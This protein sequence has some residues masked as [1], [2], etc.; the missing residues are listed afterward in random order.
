MRRDFIR[1]VNANTVSVQPDTLI[2]IDSEGLP[3]LVLDGPPQ[4][5]TT[6][7]ALARD[8]MEVIKACL[9][10]PRRRA[11]LD[12]GMATLEALVDTIRGAT[13]T[14]MPTSQPNN[15][16][17]VGPAGRAVLTS[18]AEICAFSPL[19]AQQ[20]NWSQTEA[21]LNELTSLDWVCERLEVRQENLFIRQA[22]C[23]QEVYGQLD[24]LRKLLGPTV[25]VHRGLG[26]TLKPFIKLFYGPAAK[27]AETKKIGERAVA[28]AAEKAGEKA[29][30]KG[31]EK[32]GDKAADKPDDKASVPAAKRPTDR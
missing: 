20:V 29:E 24:L 9:F 23:R 32:A 26:R 14:M 10:D 15:S 21:N 28:R 1:I 2:E 8:T 4:K 22:Y 13:D 19:A 6:A 5:T 7:A 17:E 11:D 30:D 12:R 27:A 31:A 18:R 25:E 3:E 16:E